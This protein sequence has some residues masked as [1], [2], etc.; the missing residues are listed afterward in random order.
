MKK[1]FALACVAMLCASGVVAA[2]EKAVGANKEDAV[3][4]WVDVLVARLGEKNEV[5]VRSIDQALVAVGTPAIPALKKVAA[6]KDTGSA[7]RATSLIERIENPRAGRGNRPG[8]GGENAPG[9]PGGRFGNPM[10]GVDLADDQ[11]AKVE[12]IIADQTAKTREV[13]E[14]MRNGE[15]D[16]EEMREA[17]QE[18]R[19]KQDAE[20]KK[21]LTDEQ[22]K[23]YQ[24]NANRRP[25][26]GRRGGDG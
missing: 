21:V 13:I 15:M 5:V 1:C 18:A 20:L 6:G 14:A 25:G 10:E 7:T 23:K 3:S 19:Q 16:R 8:R 9:G 22:F 17:F 26:R 12:K 2:Q 4:L 11:K 24:E